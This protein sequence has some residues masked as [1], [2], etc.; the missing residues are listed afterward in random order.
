MT[1]L[2][3]FSSTSVGKRI[4][5]ALVAAS[6]VVGA[7]PVGNAYAET[8]APVGIERQ[9]AAEQG[10]LGNFGFAPKDVSDIRQDLVDKRLACTEVVTV[11]ES[12]ARQIL[13]IAK[14][15]GRPRSERLADMIEVANKAMETAVKTSIHP[16]MSHPSL[17]LPMDQG[18]DSMSDHFKDQISDY[19]GNADH[20]VRQADQ[21][22]KAMDAPAG[23]TGYHHVAKTSHGHGGGSGWSTRSALGAG[24]LANH[25]RGR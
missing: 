4:A 3:N 11:L 16:D 15:A 14:D 21:A 22:L 9:V 20:C 12:N 17:S 7:L 5:L 1:Q 19:V 24:I 18:L 10:P 6:L 25:M 8:K 2:E 23:G 13:D